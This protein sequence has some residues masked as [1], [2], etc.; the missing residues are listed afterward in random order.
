MLVKLIVQNSFLKF[1]K[2]QFRLS[3]LISLHHLKQ[4]I[5]IH[6][7]ITTQQLCL[8]C[9]FDCTLSMWISTT[10]SKRTSLFLFFNDILQSLQHDFRVIIIIH[11]FKYLSPDTLFYTQL[12]IDYLFINFRDLSFT[13][14]WVFFFQ[15]VF[16]LMKHQLLYVM[17]N[18]TKFLITLVRQDLLEKSH[19]M[20]LFLIGLN[21][22]HYGCSPIHNQAF[23]AI[24]SVKVGIH[25]LFHSLTRLLII[26]T[27]L[28]EF[29]FLKVDVINCVFQ[30]FQRKDSRG[31]ISW[32]LRI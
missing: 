21:C 27:F 6:F 30:L 12:S 28:I 4:F 20:I 13:L 3:S 26:F 19:I 25:K 22:L 9:K 29:Y 31:L 8:D 7:P 2:E 11:F 16:K 24:L 17:L 15:Q 14:K 1:S 5:S 10:Q 18:K 23:Q 32:S